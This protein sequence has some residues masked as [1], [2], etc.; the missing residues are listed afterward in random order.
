MQLIYPWEGGNAVSPTHDMGRAVGL[1]PQLLYPQYLPN[2]WSSMYCYC[3][4]LK[5]DVLVVQ[6]VG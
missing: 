4:Q 3:W 6:P 5:H 1:T 2:K